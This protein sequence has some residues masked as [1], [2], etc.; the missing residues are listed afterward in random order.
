MRHRPRPLSRRHLLAGT[1]ALT[2]GL[3]AVPSVA[4][5][6]GSAPSAD[7]LGRHA[8]RARRTYDALQHHFHDPGTGLYLETYPRTEAN[9]WSYVWPFSQALVGTQVLAGIRGHHRR[10]APDVAARFAALESYWNAGTEPPGYD[11]YV[12]PPLGHGGDKFYDD[13]E[14][15][16]LAFIQRHL[17]SSGGDQAALTRAAEIFDLVVHGWDTDPD[18]PCPGGVFWTQADWSRDRNT[19]SNAPGAEVGLHLYLLTGERYYLDWA[20]RMYEWVRG[21]LLAP[22]GLYW[23]SIRLDGSIWEAQFSYNQGV[24]IGAGALLY[25]ATGEPEYL[26]QARDTATRALAHYA[27]DDRYFTQPARFHA[28]FFANL[29]RLGTL[30]PDPAYYDAMRAYAEQARARVHDPDTGL[31]RFTGDDPVLLLE[32][33]GMLRIEAMLAWHPDD[34]AMLT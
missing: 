5:A 14:W 29:L 3:V 28:I 4:A 31:Y 26:D 32:Q 21:C 23:D 19:V 1:A 10:Y 6:R 27:A 17:M 8:R 25:R 20:L 9:P 11:S 22:N 13:N 12:R 16:A 18:H 24:M 33:A 15:N 2:A 30:R 7:D 34:H